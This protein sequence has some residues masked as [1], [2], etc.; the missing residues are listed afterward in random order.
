MKYL[1]PAIFASCF[2]CGGVQEKKAPSTTTCSAEQAISAI[3]KIPEIIRREHY[4][5]SLTHHQ[6][7]VSFLTDTVNIDGI[8][9]YAIHVGFDGE[10]HR[11][12][13]FTFYVDQKN[14]S[15]ILADEPVEG[16][17]LPLTVWQQRNKETT[18]V[19]TQPVNLPFDFDEYY[20]A[21]IYP[22]DKNKCA[23]NYPSY[24]IENDASLKSIV[25]EAID[26]D[27]TDY[28]MLPDI[29]AIHAYIIAYTQTDVERYYLVT[30]AHNKI[31]AKLQ[32]GQADDNQLLYFVIDKDHVI[33]LYS[34]KHKREAGTPQ[35]NYHVA[36]DGTIVAIKN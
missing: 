21:C 16:S 2:A 24:P 34:R 33:H 5:D 14:C 27:A 23:A 32:I 18:P 17:R 30:L 25:E 29:G 8:A 20:N 26:E 4:F 22:G 10:F 28:F 36:A 3:R 7:G 35:Q 13:F 9:Y 11:E 12:N 31:I 1:L 19:L 6:K 15:N